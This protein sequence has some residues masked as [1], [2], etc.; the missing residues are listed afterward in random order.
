MS[1]QQRSVVAI[2][3]RSVR[4]GMC[5]LVVALSAATMVI[6]LVPAAHAQTFQVLHNFTQGADGYW[7]ATGVAID[8]AGN[9]YGISQGGTNNYGGVVF[10]MSRRGSSWI[11]TPIHNFVRTEGVQPAGITI[12]PDGNVYGANALGG[13][14]GCGTNGCG[15]VF[16]LSPPARFCADLNCPW[17]ATVLYT[18][19]GGSDGFDPRAAVIF[20]LA[21]NLYGTTFYGGDNNYC[22]GVAYELSHAGGTW[23]FNV[24]HAFGQLGDGFYPQAPVILD[25]AGNLYGTTEQ[26]GTANQGTVFQMSPSPSRWNETLLWSFLGSPDGATA[27]GGVV[28]DPAGNVYST[29]YYGGSSMSCGSYGCGTVSAVSPAN[30][31][32]TETVLHSFDLSNGDGWPQAGLTMDAAGNL[33]GTTF[34]NPGSVFKLTPTN[35]GWIYTILH[36]FQGYDGLNPTSTVAIDADGNLYGTTSGGGAN[37]YGV[38]WEITP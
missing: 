9:L 24:L 7:P 3:R 26:G 20:D 33:Y 27:L 36:E 28:V 19:G 8:R 18:F 6:G 1:A 35:G 22:C 32:W 11:F 31:G 5:V 25:D 4:A 13:G 37:S 17:P 21:G 14:M 10:K 12:G 2:L 23:A 30:G 38:V 16:K 29:T 34:R 15:T